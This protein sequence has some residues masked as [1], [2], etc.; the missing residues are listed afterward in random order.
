MAAAR[1]APLSSATTFRR[2]LS[3]RWTLEA[4]ARAWDS[5]RQ[6]KLRNKSALV[7]STCL[8]RARAPLRPSRRERRPRSFVSFASPPARSAAR[9]ENNKLALMRMTKQRAARCSAGKAGLWECVL[10]LAPE[11]LWI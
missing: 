6:R 1:L 7:S 8:E 4:R 3:A 10:K 9:S 2:P 11:R 5:P